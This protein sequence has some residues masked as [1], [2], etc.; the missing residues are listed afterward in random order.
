DT[1]A[2]RSCRECLFAHAEPS[3]L[4]SRAMTA[5]VAAMLGLEAQED[6]PWPT[7]P[8]DVSH[9]LAL[10]F[11]DE[12]EPEL[13]ARLHDGEGVRPF[14]TCLLRAG[15][16]SGPVAAGEQAILRITTFGEGVGEILRQAILPALPGRVLSL[17]GGAYRVAGATADAGEHPFAGTTSYEELSQAYL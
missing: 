6:T 12:V 8:G 14:T 13:A 15:R 5:I 17:G 1:S 4:R 11:I 7:S 2:T 16:R 10:R 3:D 9:A